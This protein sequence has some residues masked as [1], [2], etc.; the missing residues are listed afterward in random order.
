MQGFSGPDRRKNL[1][2]ARVVDQALD[3]GE[4]L[5]AMTAKIIFLRHDIP[6]TVA[7]RVLFHLDRRRARRNFNSLLGMDDIE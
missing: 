5:G 6:S 4:K 1:R 2:V 3:C 7:A